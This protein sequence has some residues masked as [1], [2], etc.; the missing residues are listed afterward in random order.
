MST[1]DPRH[2][3]RRIGP[4]RGIA[5]ARPATAPGAQHKPARAAGGAATTHTVK[6]TGQGDVTVAHADSDHGDILYNAQLRLVFWGREWAAAGAPVAPGAVVG[7]VQSI[8]GGPYLAALAQYG[9]GRVWVDRIIDRSDGDPPNPFSSGDAEDLVSSLI[10]DGTVPEPGDDGTPALYI[11]FLPTA[12]A[13]QPLGLPLPTTGEHTR[14]LDVDWDDLDVNAVPVAW[15]SHGGH[16]DDITTIFSHELVEALTDPQGDGW[17]IDPR[18]IFDWHEIADVCQ[19][20]YRLNGVLVQSYWSNSDNACVVPDSSFTTFAVEWIDRPRRIEWLG[21]TDQ[22]GNAWQLPRN[23]VMDRIRAGDRFIVKGAVSGRVSTVGIH[24]LD[25]T[26]P[27][28][29][30]SM[31]GV[32]DDN[33][34]ALPPGTPR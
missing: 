8:L 3:Q 32:V 21:G 25:A 26:H 15:V 19:S 2:P 4:G 33:L 28:L 22:D 17:Q 14:L 10:G 31:D 34:L 23:A 13:G 27:Y 9:I 11:V 6:F 1:N 7:A 30:T 20:T 16:L 29:A 12:V 5:L 18:S 24:Y